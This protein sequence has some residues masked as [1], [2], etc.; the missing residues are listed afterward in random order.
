VSISLAQKFPSLK[1]IVRDFPELQ[2]PFDEGLP[3]EL[4]SQVTFEPNDF[5]S[6]QP[7]QTADVFFLRHILHD[8]PD[9]AAIKILRNIINTQDGLLKDGTRIIIADSV[10][11]PTG[12]FPQPLE[13]LITSLDLQMWCALNAGERTKDAWTG[14]FMAADERLEVKAFVQPEG[15]ADTLIELVFRHSKD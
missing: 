3:S 7:P 9:T 2:K 10:M 14:L 13:R 4:K 8:W 6:S 1:F 5:F 12:T 15:S 11:P